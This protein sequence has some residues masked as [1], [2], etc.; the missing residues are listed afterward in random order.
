MLRFLQDKSWKK[1]LQEHKNWQW[2]FVP[3]VKEEKKLEEKKLELEDKNFRVD[4]TGWTKKIIDNVPFLVSPCGGIK[5]YLYTEKFPELTGEQLFCWEAAI[6][7]TRKAGKRIPTDEEF[8]Q[9]VKED[10][11]KVLYA[12]YCSSGGSCG[13]R[14]A[15]A[16]YWSSSPYAPSPTNSLSR[17]INYSNASVVRSKDCQAFSFSV[18]CLKG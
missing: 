12:G 2:E 15:Y 4:S 18:R 11:G 16:Y 1:L 5:E 17:Y 8:N 10:F 13:N 14:G 7:E 9:F 3:V 6:R